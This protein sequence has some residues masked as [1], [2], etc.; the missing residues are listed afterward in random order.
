MTHNPDNPQVDEQTPPRE[1]YGSVYG[2]R[3]TY[4]TRRNDTFI[5]C[6]ENIPSQ[7]LARMDLYFEERVAPVGPFLTGILAGHPW[8]K[9]IQRADRQNK[10]ILHVYMMYLYN[11]CPGP[12]WGSG[13]AM[14][15]WLNEEV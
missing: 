11:Y 3:L 1:D 13:K 6:R 10:A 2:E 7:V 14:D 9:V 12:A 8:H 5:R 15:N 4:P